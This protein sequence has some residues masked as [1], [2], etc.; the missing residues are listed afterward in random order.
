[1]QS[2]EH[3]VSSWLPPGESGNWSIRRITEPQ[4]LAG[5]TGLYEKQ[6]ETCHGFNW[7]LDDDTGLREHIPFVEECTG[8]VI[9]TGLGIGMLPAMLTRRG[10]CQQIDIVEMSEDVI[11]LVWPHLENLSPIVRLIR[12]NANKYIPEQ[13]Y[14]FGW[15]DH[16]LSYPNE[17]QKSAIRQLWGSRVS[18]IRFWSPAE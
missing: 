18:Q 10:Q 4:N 12:E 1:M 2:T 8:K 15:V 6:S 5:C 11:E 13:H 9:L 7:M 17:T 3:L 16:Y 14:D